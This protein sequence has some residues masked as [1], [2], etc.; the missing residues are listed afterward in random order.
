MVPKWLQEG[1]SRLVVTTQEYVRTQ[2]TG[3]SDNDEKFTI[4]GN[5]LEIVAQNGGSMLHG[6]CSFPF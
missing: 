3:P 5:I 1:L 4:I 2:I 6:I